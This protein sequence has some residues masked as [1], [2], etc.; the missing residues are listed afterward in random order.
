ML[1]VPSQFFHVSFVPGVF[2]AHL[3]S[4]ASLRRGSLFSLKVREGLVSSTF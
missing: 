2:H 1:T 3:L 4:V